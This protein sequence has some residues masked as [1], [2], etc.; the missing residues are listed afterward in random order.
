[1]SCLFISLAK[2][3]NLNHQILRNTLVKYL[4]TN[5][6]LLDDLNANEIIK[7]TENT[8][9]EQYTERMAHTN[10]WGGAIEIK[11]FCDLFAVNVTV[12]VL[13]T[14]KQFTVVSSKEPK[15][16]IHIEYTGSHFEPKYSEIIPPPVTIL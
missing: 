13:Y 8:S 3:L 1:M 10:V 5:P 6:P 7:Y 14:G 15:L 12:H 4:Q 16:D 9:L 11:A 2:A